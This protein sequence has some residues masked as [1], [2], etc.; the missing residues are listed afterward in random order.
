MKDEKLL[1][2]RDLNLASL[3]VIKGVKLHDLQWSNDVAFWVF[4]E[5]EELTDQLIRDFINSDVIGNIKK[6]CE[7]QKTLKAMLHNNY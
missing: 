5:Q 4:E 2:I 3:L 7:A 1:K 6:F